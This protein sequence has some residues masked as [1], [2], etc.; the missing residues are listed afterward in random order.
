MIGIGRV[1]GDFRRRQKILIDS[2]KI[3]FAEC[4]PRV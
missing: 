4:P 3:G 1:V 2:E